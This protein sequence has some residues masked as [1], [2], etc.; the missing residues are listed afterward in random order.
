MV[1]LNPGAAKNHTERFVGNL[2]QP[3]D[4]SGVVEQG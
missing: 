1:K 4:L 2:D 3:L